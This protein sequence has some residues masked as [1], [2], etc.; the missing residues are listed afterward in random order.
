MSLIHKIDIERDMSH[1]FVNQL[2]DNF[3]GEVTLA[4]TCL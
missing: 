4:E 3:V 2:E 1:Y